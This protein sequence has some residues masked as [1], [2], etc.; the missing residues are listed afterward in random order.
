MTR[1]TC[2]AAGA[3]K[4]A[5]TFCG[6]SCDPIVV[7]SR[8][9]C[10]AGRKD[11]GALNTHRG[12]LGLASEKVF[13]NRFHSLLSPLFFGTVFF[14]AGLGFLLGDFSALATLFLARGFASAAAAICG[15]S[16]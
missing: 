1:N 9:I 13:G 6:F 2:G 7:G 14:T 10:P 8:P 16:T 3:T 4:A 12:S 5:P 11:H 15:L